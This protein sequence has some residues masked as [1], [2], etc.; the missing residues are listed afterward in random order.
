MKRHSRCMS[1]SSSSGAEHNTPK[2]FRRNQRQGLRTPIRWNME[3]LNLQKSSIPQ[4]YANHHRKEEKEL[5]RK[6]FVSLEKVNN[7]ANTPL[8]EDE[9]YDLEPVPYPHYSVR[10]KQLY[11]REITT[12]SE[13][14]TT[15]NMAYPNRTLVGSGTYGSVYQ[16]K[17]PMKL[18][19]ALKRIYVPENKIGLPV[20]AVREWRILQRLNHRNIVSLLDIIPGDAIEQ[21]LLG[22]DES[23]YYR[24]FL[25]VTSLWGRLRMCEFRWVLEHQRQFENMVPTEEEK[26]ILYTRCRKELKQRNLAKRFDEEV[27]DCI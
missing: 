8:K 12:Q 19:V 7:L 4:R 27:L 22:D 3:L 10:W 15:V 18:S 17:S 13:R 2:R 11:S 25:E 23:L 26:S 21:F 20:S 9:M 5:W 6:V 24:A 14:T 16:S 1:I